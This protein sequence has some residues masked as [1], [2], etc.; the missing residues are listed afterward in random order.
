MATSRGRFEGVA[1]LISF[2]GSTVLEK[3]YY[4]FVQSPDNFHSNVAWKSIVEVARSCSPT[5][6]GLAEEFESDDMLYQCHSCFARQDLFEDVEINGVQKE[7][8]VKIAV[9]FC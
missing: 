3:G 8:L 1:E 4:S 7:D 5:K 9:R 2:F 6:K